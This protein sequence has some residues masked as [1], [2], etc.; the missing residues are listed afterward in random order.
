MQ[1]FLIFSV[2]CKNCPPIVLCLALCLLYCK[3]HETTSFKDLFSTF[4]FICGVGDSERRVHCPKQGLVRQPLRLLLLRPEDDH[5]DQ[6]LRGNTIAEWLS[7]TSVPDP[8][9][10]P[11][12]THVFVPP[13]SGSTNQRYGS[14]SFCHQA[15]IV[16]KPLIPTVF[17]FKQQ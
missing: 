4:L 3:L 13:G 8:N 2:L 6:V 9:P 5:Q 10:D 1:I 17:F 12:D 16:R 11:P 14:G 15:K 7:P